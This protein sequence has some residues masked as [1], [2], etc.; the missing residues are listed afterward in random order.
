[1]NPNMLF[2]SKDL[3]LET[4]G[5]VGEGHL[6]NLKAPSTCVCFLCSFQTWR[7]CTQRPSSTS[8]C[9]HRS[10]KWEF[11]SRRRMLPPRKISTHV[12]F[13]SSSYKSLK[14]GP[15]VVDFS[16]WY[17]SSRWFHSFHFITL[18]HIFPAFLSNLDLSSDKLSHYSGK[19]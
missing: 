6:A 13:A 19:I 14:K 16:A 15:S 12:S 8:Q 10:H 2:P 3:L 17:A 1:M 5:L 18:I 4:V 9:T 7:H 11:F